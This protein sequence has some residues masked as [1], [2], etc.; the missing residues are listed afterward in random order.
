MWF[1]IVS[2]SGFWRESIYFCSRKMMDFFAAFASE[3]FPVRGSDLVY[4]FSAFRACYQ[5]AH[6]DEKEKEEN[7]ATVGNSL[8]IIKR[9][10]ISRI[11]CMENAPEF[12]DQT[13]ISL[14]SICLSSVGSSH[15]NPRGSCQMKQSLQ[16]GGL[17]DQTGLE[18]QGFLQS[19]HT[20]EN[21]VCVC[22]CVC[23]CAFSC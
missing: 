22:V 20:A 15:S 10:I 3:N 8:W 18:M 1:F 19:C 17:E 9:K 4:G 23:V 21:T 11:L 12:F 13:V 2:N 16:T 14:T 7:R 5:R 6:N